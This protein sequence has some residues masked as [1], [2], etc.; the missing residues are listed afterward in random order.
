M[1]ATHQCEGWSATSASR[2]L[3][4]AQDRQR[5]PRAR[6][7]IQCA[8]HVRAHESIKRAHSDANVTEWSVTA[9]P[10]LARASP[11]EVREEHGT[12]EWDA[13]THF[14]TG[15]PERVAARRTEVPT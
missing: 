4:L 12:K 15:K 9:T 2:Q 8:R 14:C 13:T 10:R 11:S 3:E 7:G 5:Q 1:G 6:Y